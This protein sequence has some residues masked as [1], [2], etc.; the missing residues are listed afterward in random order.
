MGGES[1]GWNIW[2]GDDLAHVFNDGH[3]TPGGATIITGHV[4]GVTA[5]ASSCIDVSNWVH[6]AKLK[7]GGSVKPP[8]SAG[9]ETP[10]GL[11]L[12]HYS[13]H[14]CTDE[15]DSVI[16]SHDIPS[17]QWTAI[18][19][20][21][22][23][24]EGTNGIR[25][26]VFSTNTPSGSSVMFDD[27]SLIITREAEE[28][29]ANSDMTENLDGWRL[30]W[31]DRIIHELDA[32]H[33]TP[34]GSLRTEG[35]ASRESSRGKFTG[36]SSECMDV[37]GRAPLDRYK[38]AASS[39]PDSDAENPEM[40]LYVYFF[41][42]SNCKT[43]FSKALFFKDAYPSVWTRLDGTF[44]PP[45]GTRTMLVVVASLGISEDG[46]ALFDD[47]SL[48]LTQ[49]VR[50]LWLIGVG[51]ISNQGIKPSDMHYTRGGAFGGNFDPASIG[52]ESFVSLEIEFDGCN[53]GHVTYKGNGLNG[54]YPIIRLAPN[55]A[56]VSC[57]AQGF[58]N[59]ADDNSWMSGYWYGSSDKDGEG[60]V[61]DVLEG[62]LRAVVTWYTY[63]PT[64]GI[65]AIR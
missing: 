60:F 64:R 30:Y 25:V 48:S 40:G 52:Q 28:I 1:E 56:V 41:S 4:D 18:N 31:G 58:Q 24:L 12:Y 17:G 36:M 61:I 22:S 62:S 35:E 55:E 39:R 49:A 57:E 65:D 10:A 3:I 6:L 19:S 27:I 45:E 29:F 16:Q 46:G 44:I 50:Q 33:L 47:I 42:D 43:Q 9:E 13:D 53:S 51:E 20:D 59:M 8:S 15:I 63:L 21:F 26:V 7:A 23:R 34:G 32:G 37:S 11:A 5:I 2:S 38:V 54:S 14:L